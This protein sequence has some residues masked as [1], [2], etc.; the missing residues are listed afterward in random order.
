MGNIEAVYPLSPLQQGMLFHSLYS[1]DSGVYFGQLTFTLKGDFDLDAFEHAW[2]KVAARHAILRTAFVW[3]DLPE[4]VQVVGRSVRMPVELQDW[5]GLPEGE[6]EERIEAYL[7]QDRRRYFDLSTA[8]LMRLGVVRLGDETYHVVWSN[9][10]LVTDGWSAS[11]FLKEVF[12]FYHAHRR[13]EELTLPPARPYQDFIAWLQKQDFAA[14]ESFWRDALAGFTTPTQLLVDKDPSSLEAGRVDDPPLRS[15]LSEEA[16]AALQALARR[17]RLTV[18]TLVNGAW[19]IIMSRYSGEDDVVFGATVSGRPPALQGIESMTGVFINTLPVRAR[20]NH[21]MT[22]LDW[23]KAFH[24]YLLRLLQHQHTPLTKVHEW[25]DVP[26]SLPLFNSVL[27][28][29]N[30]PTEVSS[31]ELGAGLQVVP[32]RGSQPT[33]YPLTVRVG[34]GRRLRLAIEYPRN[35]FDKDTVARILSHFKN[36]LEEMG[37]NLLRPLYAVS[38]L[39]NEEQRQWLVEFN[40]SAAN[41][42]RDECLHQSFEDQAARRPDAPALIHGDEILSYGELNTRANQLAHHLRGLGVRPNVLVGICVERSPEMVVGLLGIAKAGGAYLPLDPGYPKERLEFMLTDAGAPVL[43]TQVRLAQDLPEHDGQ[44]VLLDADW[45]IIA[46]QP[47]H[48]VESGVSPADLVYVI[49]T[50]GSTG[51]PKGVM[52][53]HR[54]RVNN[55]TDFNRRFKIAAGDRLLAV[56]SLSFDMSAYDVFGV[57][58]AGATIV[59]PEASAAPDL[60]L[61]AELMR[62]HR[63]SIWHSAPALLEMLVDYAA[64]HDSAMHSLRLVLLGG[65]WIPVTLPDRLKHLVPGVEVISL[66]GATEA[67]MDSVIYR[68]V[69]SDPDW[70]SIPYGRPMANQNCY[71]L[72]A[73]LNFVPCGMPGELYLGGAGV[74]WGYLNRPELTAEKFIPHPFSHEPG[75]RLYRTGDLARYLPAGEIELLGRIDNQVKI[76]GLRVELGEIEAALRAHEGLRECVVVARRDE[77][78]DNRLV[79]YV[80]P[81]RGLVADRGE[82]HSFLRRRLPAYMLPSAFV[83]LDALPLTPNGKVDRRNLPALQQAS[84]ALPKAGAPAHGELAEKLAARWSEVLGVSV[85]IDDNFFDLG[86]DSIKAMRA[87]QMQGEYLRII[88]LYKNPTVRQLVSYLSQG[89]TQNESRLYE[90]AAPTGDD[91]VSLICVPYGGGNAIVY[92]PL[93]GALSGK[94]GLYSAG[95]PGH[96]FSQK[97]EPLKPIDEAARL[98]TEEI[99]ARVK[100]RMVVYG[101]CAGT[102]VAVELARQLEEAGV[103]IQALILGASLPYARKPF[104]R[105]SLNPLQSKSDQQLHWYFKSL[106]GFDELPEEELAFVMKSLRHDGLAGQEYFQR[107]YKSKIPPPKLKAPIFCIIGGHD[108]LTKAYRKHYQKWGMFSDSVKLILLPDGGHYFLKYQASELAEI[109]ERILGGNAV[110][111]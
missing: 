76:H 10:H 69:D 28:F 27:A 17:H 50:S 56:S 25:S 63:V 91:G 24:A 46:R 53:D 35:R 43:L 74:A 93:A 75:A 42:P 58:G 65:D 79:A 90:L 67:S 4:P 41:F 71:L 44:T 78:G 15:D 86:G 34:A 96:D 72:N 49:Y 106:G 81:E 32:G 48:N 101:H 9:H 12:A 73:Q 18:N 85:G 33:N 19:A 103:E 80:V 83:S 98:C 38:H 6:R 92:Q 110:S 3:E 89:E 26:R 59:L 84:D 23:L 22:L 107:I 94:C 51:K 55:F 11:L 88:D 64:G 57:L 47:Y 111:P 36:L 21:G 40:D 30:Y 14:S 60:P 2:Q 105:L 29:Q 77:F 100:G 39:T 8:P 97:E 20:I 5:R 16:T 87:C 104:Y 109:I 45:P 70:K 61:Y 102:T 52:L 108:P 66:G 1:S 68:V 7:A 62:R 54:G 31:E 13:G 82:L 37:N 99:L 95:L